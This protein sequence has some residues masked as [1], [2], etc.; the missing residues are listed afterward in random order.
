MNFDEDNS[1]EKIETNSIRQWKTS[2]RFFAPAYLKIIL[3][4]INLHNGSRELR[5]TFIFL[6][7]LNNNN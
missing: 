6:K 1:N 5:W 2:T 3:K 7:K 4:N